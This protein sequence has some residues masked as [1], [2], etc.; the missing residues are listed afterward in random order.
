MPNITMRYCFIPTRMAVIKEREN[1]E[2][3]NTFIIN[4]NIKWYSPCGKVWQ[5]LKKLNIKLPHNTASP[6]LGIYPQKLKAEI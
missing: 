6:I 3:W 1:K 2:N 4:G 5:F